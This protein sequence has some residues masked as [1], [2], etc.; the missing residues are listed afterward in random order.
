MGHLSTLALLAGLL[1]GYPLFLQRLG[2]DGPA[3]NGV[4][5]LAYVATL[6]AASLL[7][8][9]LQVFWEV[10]APGVRRAPILSA[11]LL[12]NSGVLALVVLSV[13]TQWGLLALMLLASCGVIGF[14]FM[15]LPDRSQAYEQIVR[16]S[17]L[18]FAVVYMLLG[19]GEGYLRFH[20]L[21]VGGGGGGNPA[22][23][24]LY[25]G[26]YSRN[27]FGL[28][29][30]EFT[31]T[32][33]DGMYR[34]L[35]LGDSFTLGQGVRL[36]D[37]YPQQMETLLNAAGGSFRYEVI[38]A[39]VSG[40]NTRDELEYLRREGL[41]FAPNLVTVQFYVNDIERRFEG[42]A[43]K[44]NRIVDNVIKRPFR[45]SYVIFFLR[46]RFDALLQSLD[47]AFAGSE[48]PSDWFAKLAE[49]VEQQQPG[50]QQCVAA[51]DGLG[52]LSREAGIPIAVIIFPRPGK[53]NDDAVG[54]I[55]RA[56]AQRS[57]EA[58][59]HVVDL[60]AAFIDVRAPEQIVSEIDHHPSALLYRLAAAGIVESLR[61][62]GL[63]PQNDVRK[64]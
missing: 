39:G 46:Y 27:S 41:R 61:Q 17:P 37:T 34:I 9:R 3:Q 23:R 13:F 53:P 50:W 25:A 35:S 28:R 19:A 62:A 21:L 44:A 33:P 12:L 18:S 2:Q 5:H 11:V 26:L 36:E 29:D 57:R 55:N 64:F 1:F 14:V 56:V 43:S 6:V 7:A 54:A 42:K 40:A 51:L 32:R 58:G 38:N 20:P 49:S 24:Q 8:I 47:R 60:T 30:E 52:A 16:F 10:L 22:L 45:R 63:V 15:P 4:F 59:L 31:R 48:A